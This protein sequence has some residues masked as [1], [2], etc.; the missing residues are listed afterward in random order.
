MS[1]AEDEAIRDIRSQLMAAQGQVNSLRR[2][3]KDGTK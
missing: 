1:A 2:R 3:A